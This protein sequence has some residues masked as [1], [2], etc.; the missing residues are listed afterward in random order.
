MQATMLDVA[1]PIKGTLVLRVRI[2][3][4]L[5]Q[6]ERHIRNVLPCEMSLS[7][8]AEKTSPTSLSYNAQESSL[9]LLIGFQTLLDSSAELSWK[10]TSNVSLKLTTASTW[11]ESDVLQVDKGP[12]SHISEPFRSRHL[13]ISAARVRRHTAGCP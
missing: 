11:K 3:A 1:V 13:T 4:N 2:L 5:I 8:N 9:P 10:G 7:S 6:P 12:S